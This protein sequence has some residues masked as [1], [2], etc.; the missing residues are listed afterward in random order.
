LQQTVLVNPI[1]KP[2]AAVFK[3]F[4]FIAKLIEQKLTLREKYI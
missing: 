1:D 4:A 2:S 3:A